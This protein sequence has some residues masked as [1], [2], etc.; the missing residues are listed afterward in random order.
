[1]S[2]IGAELQRALFLDRDGVINRD[3]G[4]VGRIDDFEF[5]PGI[6]EL[7]RLAHDDLRW[8]VIVTT[9]Q[10]GIGRG[11]FDEAAYQ[12]VTDWMCERFRAE[13]TPLTA[14]YHCPYH[15][16]YGI[17][18]YK[19]DHPWRKPRP[20]MILQAAADHAVDLAGSALIGDG[21]RDMEAGAAAGVGLLVRLDPEGR[22]DKAP[23]Q[24]VV[25]D[26]ADALK[27]LRTTFKSA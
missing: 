9:N 4:Y 13:G 20:G 15:P 12:Q 6:F 5:V 16:E 3:H 11:L 26:L 21:Q 18:D 24:T 1:M 2:I 10:S 22:G 27:L 14:V 7:V 19:R 17:G 23:V 8:P 25:R